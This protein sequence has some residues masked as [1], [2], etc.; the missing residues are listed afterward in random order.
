V[1]YLRVGIIGAGLNVLLSLTQSIVSVDTSENSA[2]ITEFIQ[3]SPKL[4][5]AVF[6][7]LLIIAVPFFE[8]VVFRGGLWKL[9]SRFGNEKIAAVLVAL[10]FSF[11]HS[12]EAAFFLLPF[13]VYLSY[14]RYNHGNIWYGVIAHICFNGTALVLLPR[15][16]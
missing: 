5:V 8:E 4:L 7:C 2:L 10:I 3:S 6:Y 15:L 11:L 16:F 12:W 9:I 13:S 1:K 14:L